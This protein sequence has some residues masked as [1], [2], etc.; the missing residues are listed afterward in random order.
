MKY[1]I[2]LLSLPFLSLLAE[3]K[4]SFN[5]DVRPIL[6][7]RCYHC[8]GPDANEIKGKLQLHTFEYATHERVYKTKSGRE[9]RRDPAIIPGKPHESI[10]WERII[11]DDEDE[12]MPPIDSS[13]KQL[14]KEEKEIIRKWIT[15]GAQYEKHWAFVSPEKKA[16]Q[17]DNDEWCKNEIDRHVLKQL[18][19][20]KLNPNPEADKET[21]IR[22]LSLDLRGV[23]PS[24]AEVDVFLADSK[25]GAYERLVDRFL[26]DKAVGERLAVEWLDVSS[27]GDSRG[28]FEDG[29]RTMWPWRD[30]VVNAFNENKP[31]DEFITEQVAG[32]LLPNPSQEQLVATGFYRNNPVSNEG[33]IIDEEYLLLY[34]GERVK[35]TGIAFLGMSMDCASCH[36]HKYD[37]LSQKSF[38]EMSAYFRSIDEKGKVGKGA[39]QPFIKLPSKEQQTK[40]NTYNAE[41]AKCKKELKKV[42]MTPLSS[43]KVKKVRLHRVDSTQL[44]LNTIKFLGH[45]GSKIKMSSANKSQKFDNLLKVGNEKEIRVRGN[46]PFIEFEFEKAFDLEGVELTTVKKHFNY[47]NEAQLEYFDEKDDLIAANQIQKSE[48]LFV[49]KP[50][51][52]EFAVLLQK[53]NK[54]LL[55]LQKI[56]KLLPT[57]LVMK[58]R[59]QPRKTHI[60]ERGSYENKGEEVFPGVPESILEMDPSYPKNR[61]GLAKWLVDKRNP[62]T[63]RVTINRY[64]QLLFGKGIV[65]TAEDFGLQGDLPSNQDLLD[66]LAVDFVEN[67]W[68]LKASLKQ[69]LMSA[70]YRQSS[71][72]DPQKVK[73]D[74]E[75]KYLSYGS[76]RRLDA[77]FI[78]DNALAISG[79]L[80]DKQG[81]APVYPYQPAG[82]WKEKS[83]SMSF[84]QSKGEGLY[85]KTMYTFWRRTVPHPSSI[86]FDA[87]D[88]ITCAARRNP[89]NTPLQALVTLNDVQY[90]E[91][92][93]VLAQ[94]MMQEGGANIE[95]RLHYAW[96]LATSRQA[97]K[98]EIEL[99]KKEFEYRQNLYSAQPEQAKTVLQVGDSKQLESLDRVELA[100]YMSVAQIILNLDEVITRN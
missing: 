11:T 23:P 37:P 50:L 20:L 98:V 28:L 68:D 83:N 29:A 66:Y 76:R 17:V 61:L 5:K 94:R 10:V 38:Y 24:L 80:V 60:L 55:D 27:Y 4:V 52:K 3:D 92:A 8:H 86:V 26:S 44:I 32:D 42:D 48:E 64:W 49:L 100:S 74:G 79:L 57:T 58:E 25:E 82:L 19:D 96:R 65:K 97:K 12:V 41:I 90:V 56:D 63:A 93:R 7:D 33:G 84:K 59:K 89:T 73:V 6:A 1:I 14:T 9:R 72:Q 88:R 77:E 69:M 36:D 85:R 40:M 13:A 95:E 78:R 22:R 54:A 46:Y 99:L 71:V 34:A 16:V 2:C 30:W 15:Q 39:A 21:L 91:A 47:L 35:T 87:M 62:L 51:S 45:S 81:G 70:T 43:L 67:G 31:F 75:N 53:Q 18:E